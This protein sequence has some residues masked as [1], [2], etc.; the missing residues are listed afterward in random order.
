[1]AMLEVRQEAILSKG[2]NPYTQA[3]VDAWAADATSERAIRYTRAIADPE[4]IVLVAEYDDA[5]VGFAM[6]VPA[7]GELSAI[8][9]KP[10]SIG[11]VGHSLLSRLEDHAF[12]T[13]EALSCVAALGA[14]PFYRAN[15]YTD[16]GSIDYVDSAGISIRCMQMKKNRETLP[17]S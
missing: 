16:Q 10:N 3:T 5:L 11:R 12:R 13:A 8:Y 2:R 1:M 7:K 17:G 9:V 14:V 4:V 15:G 6:A